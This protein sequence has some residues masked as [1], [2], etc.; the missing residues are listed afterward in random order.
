M[1][2]LWMLK[3]CQPQEI[4]M[5]R[6]STMLATA[7]ALAAMGS[8]MTAN[9]AMSASL[10]TEVASALIQTAALSCP[11]GTHLGYEGKYCWRNHEN[12]ACPAGFHL[13]YEGKYC[14]RNH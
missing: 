4:A 2:M 11:P 14:W 7:L 1:H 3:R 8:A 12:E 5:F 6:K 13:G 10:L 9:A